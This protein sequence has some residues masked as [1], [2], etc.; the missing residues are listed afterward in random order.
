MEEASAFSTAKNVELLG[1][2]PIHN[3]PDI[4]KNVKKFKV[5]YYYF[6]SYLLQ[7]HLLLDLYTALHV[8]QMNKDAVSFV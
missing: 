1:L 4:I 7:Y 5:F 3:L 2:F 6:S 8:T